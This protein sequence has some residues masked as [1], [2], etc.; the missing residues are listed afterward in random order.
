MI[1]P[2]KHSNSDTFKTR[3]AE[4]RI[5]AV[6]IKGRVEQHHHRYRRIETSFGSELALLPKESTFLKASA[7]GRKDDRNAPG[8][9]D[10]LVRTPIWHMFVG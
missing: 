6:C 3:H 1:E 9:H 10:A 7:S 4:Q 2:P 8:S 5:R